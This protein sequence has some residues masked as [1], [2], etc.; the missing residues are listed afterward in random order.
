[1]HY[2]HL[3]LRVHFLKEEMK[4]GLRVF[5]QTR[6]MDAKGKKVNQVSPLGSTTNIIGLF[7]KD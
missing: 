1:M 5:L 6:P 4:I 3:L 2:S 7:Q